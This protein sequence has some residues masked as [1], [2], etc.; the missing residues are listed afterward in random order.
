MLPW[1]SGVVP[2]LAPDSRVAQ[3]L[4]RIFGFIYSS[5]NTLD[6]L[7]I[8]REIAARFECTFFDFRVGMNKEFVIEAIVFNEFRFGLSAQTA[9]AFL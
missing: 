2:S 6:P 3:A 7:P 8:F 4:R 5:D 9:C 1:R